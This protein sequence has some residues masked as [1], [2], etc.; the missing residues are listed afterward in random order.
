MNSTATAGGRT[1]DHPVDGVLR[2]GARVLFFVHRG[3]PDIAPGPSRITRVAVDL[4]S[5]AAFTAA[6]LPRY[7]SYLRAKPRRDAGVVGV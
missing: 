1:W 3:V 7:C 6:K 2:D 5:L 4:A